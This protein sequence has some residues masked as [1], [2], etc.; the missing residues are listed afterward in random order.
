VFGREVIPAGAHALDRTN[1]DGFFQLFGCEA[2]LQEIFMGIDTG[3]KR[4]KLF[5]SQ[6]V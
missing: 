1:L 5:H 4:R 6:S 2:L 3:L